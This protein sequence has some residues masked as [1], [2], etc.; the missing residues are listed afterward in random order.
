MQAGWFSSMPLTAVATEDPALGRGPKKVIMWSYPVDDGLIYVVDIRNGLYGR[1]S[2][3]TRR[4][5]RR[6]TARRP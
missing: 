3:A 4:S 5:R 2:S 1:R 6:P